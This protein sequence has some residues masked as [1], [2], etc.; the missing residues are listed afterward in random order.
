MKI[1]IAIAS[2]GDFRKASQEYDISISHICA[3]TGFVAEI[4]CCEVKIF[5]TEC[6]FNFQ[7]I[8]Y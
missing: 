2:K 3:I 8:Y 1:N 7:I 5:Q 6:D 4:S